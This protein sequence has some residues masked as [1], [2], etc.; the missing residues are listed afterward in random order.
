MPIPRRLSFTLIG[1]L[2]LA[3][4]GARCGPPLDLSQA[5]EVTDVNTGW[6]DDGLLNGV[7]HILPSISF[8]LHNR[9][10]DAINGVQLTVSFWRDGEDG[11]WVSL[12]M[13]GIGSQSLASGASTDILVARPAH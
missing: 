9:S 6:Y 7:S 13:R 8:R 1:V 10:N 2:I 3:A 4:T 11:E 12:Q 5:L